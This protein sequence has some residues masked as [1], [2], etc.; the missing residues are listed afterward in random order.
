MRGRGCAS[1]WL[2]SLAGCVLVDNPSYLA[3]DEAEASTGDE[4]STST[5]TSTSTTTSTSETTTLD[6]SSSET[7][8]DCPPG[9]VGSLDC[10]CIDM[11]L[12]D[13]GLV[14]SEGV[15]SLPA[16]CPPD[17]GVAVELTLA[18]NEFSPDVQ[19]GACGISVYGVEPDT[20]VFDVAPCDGPVAPF[21]ITV[22]PFAIATLPEQWMNAAGD[23][24]MR[25][26][27]QDEV[28]LRVSGPFD[29][30]LTHASSLD[31]GVVELADYPLALSE[32]VGDC[33]P[34]RA[35]CGSLERR[36]LLAGDALVFDGNTTMLGD[37]SSLWVAEAA[38]TCGTPRYTFAWVRP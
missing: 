27:T 33:P 3:L 24:Y 7:G 35:P 15:C 4:A 14:C 2:V 37:G 25:A 26:I 30:W 19:V 8:P 13:E 1:A 31:P 10:E 6:T 22:T 20:L 18:N 12:C 23:V 5:S 32:G 34:E 11:Q 21:S 29:L 17:Q 16:N 28:Y 9:Q 36:G 38:L